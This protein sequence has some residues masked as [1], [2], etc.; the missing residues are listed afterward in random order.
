M[1][2]ERHTE[3]CIRSD[4]CPVSS[5]FL[6]KI[7]ASAAA[8]FVSGSVWPHGLRPARLLCPWDSLGKSSRLGCHALLQG[9]FPTEGS[10]LHC[11]QVLYHLTTREAQ[12]RSL[13][14]AKYILPP[15]LTSARPYA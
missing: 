2:V 8:S 15:S 14:L 13:G 4:Q 6:G 5:W 7:S 11:R 12:A 9:V 3:V 10:N 1:T